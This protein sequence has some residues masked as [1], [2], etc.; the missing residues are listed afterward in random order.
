MDKFKLEEKYSGKILDDFT[1]EEIQK[2]IVSYIDHYWAISFASKSE[3]MKFHFDPK[4]HIR[5]FSEVN[6]FKHITPTELMSAS[7]KYPNNKRNYSDFT[8]AENDEKYSPRLEDFLGRIEGQV[9]A[10]LVKAGMPKDSTTI[11]SFDDFEY[12][13]KDLYFKIVYSIFLAIQWYRTPHARKEFK[14]ESYFDDFESQ[15]LEGSK[16][17]SIHLVTRQWFWVHDN[18]RSLVLSKESFFVYATQIKD[19]PVETREQLKKQD[20][21]DNF[22]FTSIGTAATAMYAVSKHLLLYIRSDHASLLWTPSTN[23]EIKTDF[24]YFESWD[25]AGKEV[26]LG[27]NISNI[28]VFLKKD[29]NIVY[30]K[31]YVFFSRTDDCIIHKNEVIRKCT[32]PFTKILFEEYNYV[33]TKKIEK[34]YIDASSADPKSEYVGRRF[35]VELIFNRVDKQYRYLEEQE[36]F[37]VRGLPCLKNLYFNNPEYKLTSFGQISIS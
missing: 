19:L 23:N 12:A 28:L 33:S 14:K 9:Q 34:M 16:I 37:F 1:A 2:D 31:K 10:L 24:N 21:S 30:S 11:D 15:I 22:Y 4:N 8:L 13:V 32:V 27:T 25:P 35:S 26:L 18:S 17:S 3:N 7:T 36:Q 5:R 29:L 6:Q 20:V